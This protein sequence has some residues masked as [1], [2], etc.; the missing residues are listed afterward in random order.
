MVPRRVGR[1]DAGNGDG[2]GA[3]RERLGELKR[4]IARGEYENEEKLEI[5]LERM[6]ADLRGAAQTPGA[7]HEGGSGGERP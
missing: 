4:Q 5:T 3:R 7:S 6:L 2:H 1:T